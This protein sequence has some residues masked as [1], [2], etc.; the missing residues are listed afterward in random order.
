MCQNRLQDNLKSILVY[1]SVQLSQYNSA[2]LKIFSCCIRHFLL[3]RIAYL[4][5]L[6]CFEINVYLWI[7]YCSVGFNAIWVDVWI[8]IKVIFSDESGLNLN[9]VKLTQ[10]DGRSHVK[11]GRHFRFSKMSTYFEFLL[12]KI[13]LLDFSAHFHF[14]KWS[15]CDVAS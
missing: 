11:S 8:I 12:F 7:Y 5:C 15:C 3:R 14:S 13:S 10:Y 2:L 1:Y 9:L 6:Q 4:C